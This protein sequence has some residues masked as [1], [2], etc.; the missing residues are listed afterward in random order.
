MAQ[1]LRLTHL[2]SYHTGSFDA[3][4]AEIVAHDPATQRLFFTN[5]ANATIGVLDITNPASP[6]LLFEIDVMPY[7]GAATSVDVHDGVV[8]AAVPASEKTDPGAVV[9]FTTDGAFIASATVGALPDMLIF[10]PDGS[11]VIVA[12]EGEPN[13]DYSIDPEG[14]ISI[15]DAATYAVTTVGFTDFNAGGSREAEL[16]AGVRIF[17]P[18]AS[19]AQD[20]EPEYITVGEIAPFGTVAVATLQENNAV[21]IIDVDNASVVAIVALG[22]KDHSLLENAF[23][24]SNRDAGINIQPWPVKGLYMPDA[25]ASYETN[26]Q[27]YLVTANEGDARDYD[28]FS[29]EARVG[30]DE[31]V[32]D[33]T[34]FP[35]AAELK[36]DANLGRLKVTTASGDIDGDGDFEEIHAYGAR[37]FTIWDTQGNVVYDSGSEFETRLAA[38]YPNDFNSNNDEND[39]FDSRSDDKG[40]EPEVVTIGEIDGRFYAFIGLERIGG[41]IVYDVTD[42]AAPTFVDYTNN[43]DF[44][45]LFDPATVTPA[46]IEQ[47]GDLG[48]EG[49]VFIQGS[50]SPTG[51]NMIAVANEVSGSVSLFSFAPEQA[52][53][54]FTLT[55]LHN[56]DGESQ[57][58]SA[59]GQPDFGGVARFKTLMDDLRAD[60]DAAGGVVTLSSGDNFLAGPEF[61][62]SLAQPETEAL[63][64]SRALNAIGYDA[65]AIGNHEFDFG[66][67]VLQRLIEDFEAPT[68]FLS[69]NLDF[70]AEPGLQA[71]VDNGRIAKSTIL[72]K[73]G[74]M[75]GV[76]G[77][78]TPA[79]PTISSPRGV[80]VMSDVA[81][82]VQAEIDA[83]EAA[84]VNK[85][86]LISHLQGIEQDLE[87]IPML[88]GLDIAIAGGGDELLAN[89]D[90]VLVP[91]DANPFGP[92]PL[93]VAN[94]DGVDV[95]VVTTTGNYKYIGRL[96]VEF[97]ENGVVTTIGDD[98][99]PVRVAGG[100]EPD[101]VEPDA[102]VL[103]DITAPVEAALADLAATVVGTSEV[104]LDGVRNSVRGIETNLGNLITD[105]FL[106][107]ATELA[108]AFGVPTPDVA[109]Q[110]GGGIRNDNVI[111]AGDITV[112]TTFDILPFANF[113]A[114]VP[115]LP[116][117]QFKEILENGVAALGGGA[118]S[119]RF[120]Q[121]AGIQIAVDVSRQ[122]QVLDADQNVVTPGA[123][124]RGAI[125]D[126]GRV[127]VRNGQ[128]VPGAPAITVAT[129][130][131]LAN[132]GDEFPYRGAAYTALGVTYQ[133]TLQNY[134]ADG[135]GGVVTAAQYPEGGEG[136]ILFVD[137]PEGVTFTLIDAMKDEPIAG[138]DPI[139]EG[140]V[141]DLAQLPLGLNVR[142]NTVD[143]ATSLQFA[144]NGANARLEKVAPFALF[145][146]VNGNY[147]AGRLPVGEHTLGATAFAAGEAV[148]TG[149]VS[150]SVV[151]GTNSKRD[152]LLADR[153]ASVAADLPEAFELT[154]N[155]PNPFNPTTTVNFAL[156]ESADVRVTV[157][158][159]LGRQ[160]RVLVNGTL[161][162][163]RHEVVFDASQLPSGAY[164]LQY[165]TPEG[166]FNKQMVLMK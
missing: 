124:I 60:A 140:A 75:I 80:V 37:S 118:G 102:S 115:E 106:W 141:L 61:S 149:T 114:V 74:E 41:V 146:D 58:I 45:V 67:D 50:D 34:V 125:L 90:D 121:L 22:T 95:P 2:G 70:S 89:N 5:S 49:I 35:N 11:K 93:R 128:V 66:P 62:V 130:D 65:L 71:L 100:A 76:I 42:P 143:E 132:G 120:A 54:A 148:Q 56:N 166:T 36:D 107:Q 20:L 104:A 43:R 52:A 111:P 17:G 159:M 150:F 147:A 152:L 46:E 51:G 109:I 164:F 12:N 48:P 157:F 108:S 39:S 94:A 85:I 92:Y 134:I 131:F 38:I 162:A 154:G 18:G 127:I 117:A 68:P 78:T 81:G 91:G 9:F 96:V 47:V 151:K 79:L 163:G 30:D 64:E 112:L 84:G 136:R 156:P 165:S 158:D 1:S 161:P 103:A 138:Y 10:T 19:V 113:L 160:V 105:G 29:E 3:S 32:L 110:N 137:R 13:S 72:E 135:L 8:A 98:S 15:V 27:T 126:D 77:A 116:A 55:V 53:G 73:D 86:I 14:S 83:L 31:Y 99:G 133:Q 24:A 123:R 129:I 16:P 4:A 153:E 101:A 44:S 23:D 142:A 145:G 26:G 33:P 63:Y 69:A 82:I 155:Y 88:S 97:D 21:A 6:S 40:P 57:L 144:L 7:G 87:L 119:G 28:G 139:E 59:P 122:P 25:I